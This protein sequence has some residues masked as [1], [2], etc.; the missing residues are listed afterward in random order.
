M[1]S[2]VKPLSLA[3]AIAAVPLVAAAQQS[4]I[5]RAYAECRRQLAGVEEG[6]GTGNPIREQ[7][8]QGCAQQ[9][10]RQMQTQQPKR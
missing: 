5:D 6:P 8:I 2:L 1:M 10:L 3:L 4:N 7:A 9:K